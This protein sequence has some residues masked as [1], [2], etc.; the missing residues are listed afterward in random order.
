MPLYRYK[1]IE[2]KNIIHDTLSLKNYLKKAQFYYNINIYF[3][4]RY[5][6]IKQIKS[7]I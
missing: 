7:K 2:T 5:I 6:G 1:F 3:M 4:S